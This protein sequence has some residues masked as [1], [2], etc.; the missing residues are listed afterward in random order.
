MQFELWRESNHC[1]YD[2]FRWLRY[3]VIRKNL[4]TSRRLKNDHSVITCCNAQSTIN[5]QKMNWQLCDTQF[6]RYSIR[7]LFIIYDS[8][9]RMVFFTVFWHFFNEIISWRNCQQMKVSVATLCDHN[10]QN[11]KFKLLH[12]CPIRQYIYVISVGIVRVFIDS[13]SRFKNPS[14]HRNCGFYPSFRPKAV[15]KRLES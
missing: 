3:N 11:K 1:C 5:Q 4:I 14:V 15:W 6:V 9:L 7:F 13:Q 12:T 8:Q 2:Y 10:I